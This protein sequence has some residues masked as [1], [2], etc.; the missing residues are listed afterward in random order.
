MLR[1][2]L[3]TSLMIQT[4]PEGIGEQLL[5]DGRAPVMPREGCSVYLLLESTATLEPLPLA[6]P[7]LGLRTALTFP[8]F[9]PPQKN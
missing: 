8:L 5:S 6:T 7:P 3:G 2:N 1:C 4:G 9:P